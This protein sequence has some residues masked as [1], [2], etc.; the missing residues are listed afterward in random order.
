M[1]EK[2]NTVN[3]APIAKKPKGQPEFSFKRTLLSELSKVHP[4]NTPQLIKNYITSSSI[5]CLYSQPGEGKTTVST[6]MSFCIDTGTY[7]SGNRTIKGCVWYI[8]AEDSFGVRI[9]LEACYLDNDANIEDS[10]IEIIDTPINFFNK[11][12]VDQFINDIN[13]AANKPIMIVIDTLTDIGAFGGKDLNTDMD[14]LMLEF[15]KIKKET[16]ASILILHHS[17]HNAQNRPMNGLGIMKKSDVIIK[18]N[19]ENGIVTLTWQKIKNGDLTKAQP[20]SFKIKGV[21][22]KWADNDGEII[23]GAVLNSTDYIEK[24]TK[25]ETTQK[26]NIALDSLRKALINDG[27]EDKGVVSVTEYQWRQVAYAAGISNSEQGDA[28]KKAFGRARDT[29][30]DLGKVKV[31]QGRYWI[32]ATRTTPNKT[33]QCSPMFGVQ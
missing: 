21:N 20:L 10:N 15:E 26:Q 7:F 29:L 22:T 13:S 12:Q 6:F 28:K 18:A 9:R 8:A 16:G 5:I 4:G 1:S 30:I 33:E 27:V 25:P 24:P 32:A 3:L 31:S 2:T 17:G 14:L 19:N 11:E 23:S